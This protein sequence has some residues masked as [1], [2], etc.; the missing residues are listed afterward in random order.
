MVCLKQK[1]CT[2]LK[3]AIKNNCLYLIILA[4]YQVSD[5]GVKSL[6]HVSGNL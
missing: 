3:I 4:D 2:E 6:A 1:P 5:C